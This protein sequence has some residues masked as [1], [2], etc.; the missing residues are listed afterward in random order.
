M[1]P[2]LPSAQAKKGDGYLE[3][4]RN[5]RDQWGQLI[6]SGDLTT[7]QNRITMS[8]LFLLTLRATLFTL[9]MPRATDMRHG[10]DGKFGLSKV[11]HAR[12]YRKYSQETLRVVKVLF[13]HANFR[14]GLIR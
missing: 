2:I 9:C 11:A 7:L 13:L 8:V 4:A 14:P 12:T 1:A 3:E 6:P 10:L 5:L